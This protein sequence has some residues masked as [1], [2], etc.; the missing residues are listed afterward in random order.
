MVCSPKYR[1]G[2]R[3]LTATTAIVT[4]DAAFLCNR[5]VTSHPVTEGIRPDEGPVLKTGGGTSRLRV[6]VSRLP[7]KTMRPWCNGSMTGSNPVGQGS[8][9][10][11]RACERTFACLHGLIVQQEDTSSAHWRSGC[12]SRWV[13]STQSCGL[14]AKAAPLQGDDRGFKSLQDYLAR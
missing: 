6:R 5:S 10:W 3:G 9:P 12:N 2:A 11:G 7:L 8:S 14:V 13:H 4:I 1:T